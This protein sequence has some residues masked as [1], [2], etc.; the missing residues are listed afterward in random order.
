MVWGGTYAHICAMVGKGLKLSLTE[1]GNILCD[2]RYRSKG[3]TCSSRQTFLG[4]AWRIL[5][6]EWR[7]GLNLRVDK[8]RL[9]PEEVVEPHKEQKL[10]VRP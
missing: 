7:D 5:L 2:P 9:R 10:F 8:Q 6:T 4:K 3:K 1:T